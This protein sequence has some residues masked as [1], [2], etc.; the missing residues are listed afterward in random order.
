MKLRTDKNGKTFVI[1]TTG[2]EKGDDTILH[3]T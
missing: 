3:I 1:T 2:P